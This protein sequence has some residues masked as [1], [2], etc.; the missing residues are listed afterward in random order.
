MYSACADGARVCEHCGSTSAAGRLPR[1]ANPWPRWSDTFGT[2]TNPE[3]IRADEKMLADAGIPTH[4]D[5][6]T[7]RARV[8]NQHHENQ[9]SKFF[10]LYDKDACYRQYRP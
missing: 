2:G 8:E 4:F 1:A 10:K 3:H 5:P 6:A 9:L 7:G